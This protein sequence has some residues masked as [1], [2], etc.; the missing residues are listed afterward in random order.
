MD[1]SYIFEKIDEIFKTYNFMSYKSSIEVVKYVYIECVK[2]LL[3]TNLNIIEI[4]SQSYSKYNINCI[5]N[6]FTKDMYQYT[7]Y[8]F[9]EMI[10]YKNIKNRFLDPFEEIIERMMFRIEL[11]KEGWS[12]K[13]IENYICKYLLKEPYH[14][15]ENTLI[16]V[17]YHNLL[18]KIKLHNKYME[19]K[20]G[21][22]SL[23][24]TLKEYVK[25]KTLKRTK[26]NMR[27][28]YRYSK[29]YENIKN[30]LFTNEEF[31]FISHNIKGRPDLINKLNNFILK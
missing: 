3:T 29:Y 22:P 21:R 1:N 17:M 5:I 28:K 12:Y 18:E 10:Q 13:Q 15:S 8:L 23:P 7:S 27:Q 19:K 9:A 11:Y 14:N 25:N 16:E 24:L 6:S 26:E 4:F 31:D 2:L 20:K 30:N